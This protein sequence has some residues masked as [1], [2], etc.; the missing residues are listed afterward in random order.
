M[1]IYFSLDKI[2][3]DK[4]EFV[5]DLEQL[6]RSISGVVSNSWVKAKKKMA[7][8]DDYIGR[9]SMWHS[10][11]ILMF[12]IQVAK[13]GKIVDFSEAN[14]YYDDIVKGNAPYSELVK[15]YKPI[16]NAKQ[17]EFRVLCPKT[18]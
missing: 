10:L 7:Q 16:M 11:R 18:W 8:G 6:R 4:F 5:L 12:G 1:E 17:S 13:Y 2:H 15:V 9:K 3:Q 14:E